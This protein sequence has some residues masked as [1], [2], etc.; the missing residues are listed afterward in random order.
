MLYS[1]TCRHRRASKTNKGRVEFM[2]ATILLVDNEPDNTS[3]LSMGLEDE[4]FEVDAFNDPI[5]ALSDFK[6]DFYSLS[7]LDINMP[8][9]NGYEF[10][11]EIKK[12]DAK[13]KVCFL[14]ASEIYN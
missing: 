11:R 10:F 4:G 9:M 12:L 3:V 8:K 2:T 7:I 5:L 1:K 13:I 14:T 6:P